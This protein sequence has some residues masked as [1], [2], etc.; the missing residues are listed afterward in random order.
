MN[1]NTTNSRRNFLKT[2]GAVGLGSVAAS[3]AH[4]KP[5]EP[6]SVEP[7]DAVK[8]NPKAAS[9]PRRKLGK[10]GVDVP[11]LSFG[12]M[13]NILDNQICLRSC[14]KWGVDYWDTA[15]GYANGNSELGIGQY[16]SK[17]P[18]IR[19]NLFIVTKASG[20]KDGNK[21]ELDAALKVSLDRM[22]T[23]YVDLYYGI[24]G[25]DNP[26]LLNDNLKAWAEKAKKEKK[27]RFFGFSTHKNIPECLMA[28]SKL[29]WIDVIMP[30][31][32]IT[33]MQKNDMKEA[34]EACHKKG[35]GLIAMKVINGVSK[36]NNKE[37]EKL[38]SHFIEKGF[39]DGQAKIKAVVADERFASACVRM[40]N[41]TQ[42][43]SNV[44]A[45]LDKTKL[46]KLDM[47]VI[48]QY[49]AATCSGYCAGCA[50]ICDNALPQTPY[51]SDIMR[52]LMYYNSYGDMETARQMFAEIPAEIRNNLLKVDY[53]PA[54]SRCPHR[55]PIAQLMAEAVSKLA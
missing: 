25:L 12:A 43:T 22:Q 44:A 55:M 52:Y 38:I 13:F 5:N 37:E 42:I 39:T 29:D 31:Y 23:D 1:T 3:V 19:K 40:Q 49:V 47:Q 51:V 17:D 14:L 32:N 18:Q 33:L 54:E 11:V 46:T 48:K 4:A 35:I 24:H 34:V 41:V 53:G 6:N 16:I 27:I 7:N 28:A 30:S 50:A 36:I 10:T 45:V 21:D 9:V 8:T 2:L 26:A 20:V 15:K